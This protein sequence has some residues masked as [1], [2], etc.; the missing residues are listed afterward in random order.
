VC[1]FSFPGF[2]LQE[3]VQKAVAVDAGCSS[4]PNIAGEHEVQGVWQRGWRVKGEQCPGSWRAEATADG[5]RGK[6]CLGHEC[7]GEGGRRRI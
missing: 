3:T 7:S 4:T 6:Y 2:D 5:L 1:E